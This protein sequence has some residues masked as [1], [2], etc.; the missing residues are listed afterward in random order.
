MP[1]LVVSCKD[2]TVAE[3]FDKIKFKTMYKT[4][5]QHKTDMASTNAGSLFA[6]MESA[7]VRVD[8]HER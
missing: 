4:N 1:I 3:M 5:L 2:E 8:E 6:C 7:S